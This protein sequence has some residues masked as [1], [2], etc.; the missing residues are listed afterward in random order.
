MPDNDQL[1]RFIFDNSDVRG[2]IISLS[3]SYRSVLANGN[4]PHA[5]NRLLGELLA[6]TGLLSAT[7]KFEGIF[8]LQARGDGDVSLLMADCTRQNAL[9]GI[10]RLRDGANPV[11]TELNQLLGNGH[12][13]ITID[14]A[15]GER[16][17]GIV[18]LEKTTLNGCLEDYFTLSEQLP[19]RLWLFA[20]GSRAG[21]LL[22]QAL[23]LQTQTREQRDDYWQHLCIL[24][25]TLSDEEML[26][27][28]NP[29]I[30]KRLFHQENLRLFEPRSLQFACSC[31]ENRTGN[32][33]IT[34]GRDEVQSI[35]D[36]QGKVEVQCQ[37]CHQQYQFDQTQVDALFAPQRTLH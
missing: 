9:R 27:L 5:I 28:D 29:T 20:D 36:E 24:A 15:E 4:Y 18:P 8:S 6:A 33:L 16:Y 32:M 12:L 26:S 22:L 23:P 1:H 34:L 35:L 3:D 21:G 17:Q 14:P 13:A 31:S 30:L 2:E 37:F 11:A 25:D 7:M 19:T 10:A